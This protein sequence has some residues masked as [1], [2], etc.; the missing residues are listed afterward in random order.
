MLT[1]ASGPAAFA[2]THDVA[3]ATKGFQRLALQPAWPFV[4]VATFDQIF[5]LKRKS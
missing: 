4:N 3:N 1:D 2:Q 5:T